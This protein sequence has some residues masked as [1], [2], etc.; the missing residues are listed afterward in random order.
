MNKKNR[1]LFINPSLN[2]NWN[3]KIRQTTSDISNTIINL[4]KKEEW[5]LDEL[6][7]FDKATVLKSLVPDE[8]NRFIINEV[9]KNEEIESCENWKLYEINI[10]VNNYILEAQ[11]L[12]LNGNQKIEYPKKLDSLFS[13]DLSNPITVFVNN[14]LLYIL[15]LN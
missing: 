12:K 14:N 6:I 1:K 5:L 3:E 9:E 7:D 8:F 2:S 13:R 15:N 10:W 11:V 4:T